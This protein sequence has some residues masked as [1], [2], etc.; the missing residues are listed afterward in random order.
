MALTAYRT[1]AVKPIPTA[2]KVIPEPIMGE[3]RRAVLDGRRLRI[4]YAAPDREPIRR[5]V[6]P[7]G[8]VTVRDTGYLL[9]TVDGE[10]R[11]YRLSR[12]LDAEQLVEP[13]RRTLS[14]DL[15]ELWRA[16]GTRFRAGDAALTA[17]VRADPLRRDEIAETAVAIL[18]ETRDPDGW[19]RMH[20]TFQDLRHAV[21]AVWQLGMSAEALEPPELRATLRDRAAAI[22]TRYAEPE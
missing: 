2:L 22:A 10:D 4:R 12:I 20:V 11:T 16:R 1:P 17:V 13:A 5:T 18:E 8:L 9:A 15:E 3:V 7:I 14:V 6:D 19:L 21:W